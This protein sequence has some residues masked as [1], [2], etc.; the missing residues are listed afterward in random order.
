[1]IQSFIYSDNCLIT[2]K[3]HPALEMGIMRHLFEQLAKILVQ[4]IAVLQQLNG[5]LIH[6][7]DGLRVKW[8]DGATWQSRTGHVGV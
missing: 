1:M 5:L 4:N 7:R 8:V 6:S 3:H 2:V